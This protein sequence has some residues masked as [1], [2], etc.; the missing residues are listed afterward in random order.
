MKGK[1]RVGVI[2][3]ALAMILLVGCEARREGT[4]VED[5]M[6]VSIVS[7]LTFPE[8]H[9]EQQCSIRAVLGAG[10]TGLILYPSKYDVEEPDH[11]NGI[12]LGTYEEVTCISKEEAKA[13]HGEYVTVTGTIRAKKKGPGDGYNCEMDTITSITK[14]KQVNPTPKG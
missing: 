1:K 9:N 7:V 5:G 13:L 3:L 4:N 11:L 6:N 10:E 14:L 8:K 2:L 12:W